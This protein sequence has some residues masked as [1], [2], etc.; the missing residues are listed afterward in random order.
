MQHAILAGSAEVW[1]EAPMS[2]E[3]GCPSLRS[4]L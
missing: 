4:H 3:E 2:A 1:V